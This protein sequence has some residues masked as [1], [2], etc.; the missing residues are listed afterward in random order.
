MPDKSYVKKLVPHF[1]AILIFL[2]IALVYF[3]PVLE[4]K[5][6][7]THDTTVFS[8]MSK[9]ISDHREQYGEEPLWTNSMFAGM[10]AYLI[11]T[12][13]YGNLIKPLH[14]FLIS[15]GIPV[16]PIL[17]LMIGFYILLVSLRVNPWLAIVGSI[18]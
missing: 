2:I 10:P 12:Q 6:L 3:S 11:S 18:A 17:L 7:K 8:G 1:T 5:V 15:P 9:E 4:G 13:Y 14:Y 16:A